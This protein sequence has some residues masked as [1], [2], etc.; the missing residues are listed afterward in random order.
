MFAAKQEA[1]VTRQLLIH[2]WPF[3]GMASHLGNE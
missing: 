2:V 3:H 1:E